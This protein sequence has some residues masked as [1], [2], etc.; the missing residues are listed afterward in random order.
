MNFA[1]SFPLVG[2]LG[3]LTACEATMSSD[4]T[5]VDADPITQ[6][7]SGKR[8][9][10][11]RG[12][13]INV[14]ANGSLTGMVGPNQSVALE[15]AWVIRNGQWCRTLT[16]PSS[17]AGTD[18]QDATLNGDGTLTIDGVNGPIVFAIQ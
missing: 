11:D 1:K 9:V 12:D 15:G 7:I 13:Y 5:T 17:L 16:A 18:C 4:A 8:L 10:A 14:G 2:A 3:F 6:A